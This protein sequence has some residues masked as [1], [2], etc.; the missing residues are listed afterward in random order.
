MARPTRRSPDPVALLRTLQSTP[1]AY[2][3]FEAMRRLEC[4]HPRQP[5][6]GHAARPQDEPVRFGQRA[7]LA[8]PT[9][10]VD[11]VEPAAG[12]RPP[13][14]K[15]LPLGLFGPH[16]PLPLHLTEHAMARELLADD[17]TFAAF[18]DL[19]HHRMIALWYRAWADARPTVHMD[20]PDED[21]FGTHLDALTG[22]GQPA[23]RGRDAL[24]A[25]ARR[26][27]AGR[28]VAQAR[29]AEG[30][31]ALLSGL[32]DVPLQV[33]PFRPGWLPLPE[34]GRLRMGQSAA[35]M[36]EQATLGAHARNAQH[37]FRLRIGPLAAARYREFLPGG[38][39]LAELTS[40]VRGYIGDEQQWDVQLVLAREEVP[41]PTLGTAQRLGMSLWMGHYRRPTD[42]DE[43]V[44]AVA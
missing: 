4:A 15:T 11:G 34:D 27:H 18:A 6:L 24:P 20:R 36:G 3:M 5:R 44:L 22:V 12:V 14:L 16:G 19:F 35:R 33:Q 25:N 43:L 30:L 32:F 17:P 2:E 13:R 8:F 26:Y 39:A 41:L 37:R 21:R 40:A 10:S 23:L 1:E 9:R 31:H 29:N 42:A 7:Q 28:L 38:Q